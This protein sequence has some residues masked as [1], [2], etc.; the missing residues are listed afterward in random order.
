MKNSLRCYDVV[1]TAMR[2]TLS[3]LL[4]AALALSASFA[5]DG[6]AQ[7]VLQQKITVQVQGQTVRAVLGLVAQRADVKFLYS[8][9]LIRANRPVSLNAIDAPLEAVL[10]DL[11]TPLGLTYEVA[12]R[13]IALRRLAPPK[14]SALPPAEVEPVDVSV[15]GTVVDE[16]GGA[17]P[18]VSV[19]VKGSSRGTTTNTEGVFRLD[20]PGP[21]AVLVFSYVG[22]VKQ[23]L[24]IGNQSTLA[25]TLLPEDKTLNEVVV[26]G[27]G[28]QRRREV[29]SAVASVA[30]KDIQNQVTNNPLNA[31]A[32]QMPG[33]QITQTTGRLGANP[34]VRIRGTGSI[35]AGNSPLYVVDGI[36]L[37]DASDFN[38][39][40]PSDIETIDVLKDAASAAIYGSRGGNGVILITTKKGKAGKAR[41]DFSYYTG[42]QQVSKKIDVLGRDEHIDLVKETVNE[43]WRLAGGAASVPNGQRR[44]NN[45]PVAFNYPASY[46][47]PANLPDTDWQDLIYQK[48]PIS[49]Y[50]VSASG[51][52][53]S[54]RYYLSGNYFTQ[55]GI[56]RSTDYKRYSLRANVDATISPKIRAGVGFSPSYSAE[57]QQDT[58][59]H[60]SAGGIVLSALGMPPTYLP[61]TADG[62]YGQTLGNPEFTNTSYVSLLYS[63]LAYLEDP[64][65]KNRR[66]VLRMLGTSYVEW[67]PLKN[68]TLRSSLN[69]DARAGWLNFYRPS[70]VSIPN[71]PALTPGSPNPNLANIASTHDE[72]RNLNYAWDNTA[73]YS[74]SFG[75]AHSL[76][77]LVGYS[78]QRNTNESN[79]TSG[80]TGTF[81]N[82]LVT[83]PSAA[84]IRTGNASK[85]Y[86][87][88]LSYLAR[89]NYSFK[90]RYFLTAALRRD[91]S[92]RFAPNN[93]WALFPSVSAAWRVSDEAFLKNSAVVNEAK[94]RASYGVT[95]NFNIGN[96]AYQALLG[97]DN[98][99]FGA[100]VGTLV[101]G[102]AASNLPNPDLSWETNR[103]LD[104]GLD[105]SLWQNRLTLNADYYDRVTDGLLYS[106]PVPSVSG[107]SSVLT[108]IGSVRN[109]GVELGLTGVIFAPKNGFHWAI[110]QVFS[111][112]RNTLLKLGTNDEPIRV[113]TENTVTQI[114]QVGG[115]FGEF[116]GYRVLGIFQNQADVDAN[117]QGKFNAGSRPG[118]PKFFDANGD[119][120]LT[121]DDRVVLGNP[122]PD[123]SYGQTHRFSYKN[124]DLE[125]QFQGVQGGKIMYLASR[126]FGINNPSYSNL[127][128]ARDRWRS[129]EQPGS[130]QTRQYTSTAL[131][132]GLTE[133]LTD[134][135]LYDGSYLR[136]RNVTLGFT[137]P[138]AWLSRLP[139]R[140]VRVYAT[141]QNLLTFSQ[142]LGYNPEVSQDAEGVRTPGLDYGVYPL[143][144]TLT[145]GINLGL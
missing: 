114:S 26:V 44:I 35:S 143:A 6:K 136:L 45:S 1:V 55:D 4:L 57:N 107:F 81:D 101:G 20:V 118:D 110:S 88:L 75:E 131:P 58:D 87:S 105:L 18:G 83:Y 24:A 130:G 106:T 14:T 93:K 142:Y 61:R 51:G 67:E 98:Y 99:S 78:V 86:W 7:D 69:L 11:L 119:G 125:V 30:A 41:V 109:R 21:E 17:L 48:A 13:Q 31:L 62:L 9:T 49:N 94:L 124:L 112:N 116:Y 121:P 59:G 127:D 54:V 123:F 64:N 90:D 100:G 108:N 34:V 19:L 10:A 137:L 15:S 3:Q 122:N 97:K 47:D 113:T 5:R 139:L 89:V 103:Q 52:S 16:N 77:A 70:T 36:P 135:F 32:A 133:S 117:P 91:G 72:S 8:S 38:L 129:P 43:N 115:S 74:R 22:Y 92:S 12:G 111:L 145:F 128:L 53:E 126:F 134:R 46:D 23:E 80:Q 25:V 37:N 27:Y 141:G 84:N 76:T 138:A 63:P 79:S 42:V 56:I 104:F 85:S 71:S 28:T 82:D 33:V 60:W 120:T 66:E 95:G 132:A 65:F 29:S 40:N 96:F 2:I 68:L 102:V 144:R 73:T 50:Q 140:S 39:L